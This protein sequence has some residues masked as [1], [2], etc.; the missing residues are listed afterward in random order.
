MKFGAPEALLAL[1]V[2]P[3][4]FVYALVVRRWRSRFTIAFTNLGVLAA[5]TSRRRTH[6]W[7]RLPLIL[8]AL[9]LATAA[10]ALAEPRVQLTGSDRTAMIVLL[11]DVSQS[12]E[13][14]DIPP[15]RL[16]AAVIAMREFV[17]ELPANDKVGLVTLSDKVEVI[18][19]PTTNRDAINAGL[20]S[21]GIQG[22]TALGAGVEGAVKLIVTSLAAEHI[23]HTP[24]H[25]LPAAIV[26]ESDGGQDRGSIS[27][28][29]AGE[30]AKTAGVRIYGVA[31]GRPDAYII[32]G[33]GYYAMKI[34][35]PPDPGIVAY[36]ARESGGQAFSATNVTSLDSTYRK[37]GLSI[38]RYPQLTGISSWF[39]VAAALL[40][41]A[42][43][44]MARVRGGALP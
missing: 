15:S 17:G 13:A 2:V 44:S 36:L 4:L 7:W 28:F 1:L 35:V 34:A 24:G 18:D 20:S 19:Q 38:G 21:L 8:L 12:M 41:I 23:Y 6:W 29:V 16:D 32:N 9:A 25:Y 33:S 42:G 3:L 26:L 40:L 11:V 10:A 27:P 30:L 5:V 14:V 43:V 37:L 31:L 39:D 22:G